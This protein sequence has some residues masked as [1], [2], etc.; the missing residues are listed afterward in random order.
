[1]GQTKRKAEDLM[2]LCKE[3]STDKKALDSLQ[4]VRGSATYKLVH[5]LGTTLKDTT[6]AILRFLED[7]KNGGSSNLPWEIVLPINSLESMHTV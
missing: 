7:I 6:L 5:G 4:L 2:A 3:V 1:M